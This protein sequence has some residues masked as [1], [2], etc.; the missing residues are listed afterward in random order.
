MTYQRQRRSAAPQEPPV[1]VDADGDRLYSE[2]DYAAPAELPDEWAAEGT[3]LPEVMPDEAFLPD[4]EELPTNLPM[5]AWD[6][7]EA[8]GYGP[9]PDGGLIP[10]A[11][12][13]D[14]DPDAAYLDEDDFAAGEYAAFIRS[15]W[16]HLATLADF[17][18]V[19][20]GTAA[21]L[22]LIT[23]LVSLLNWL[24]ADIS[25]SFVLLQTRF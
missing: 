19:I 17:A 3:Y 4:A 11:P 2:E 10:N 5:D 6:W 7:P 25:Q 9:L 14:F 1:R 12:D 22:V 24:T 21:I 13:Y 8:D 18:G 16:Q 15:V 23:L 20:L